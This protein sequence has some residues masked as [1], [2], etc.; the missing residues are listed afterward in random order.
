MI[1]E[2]NV[3]MDFIFFN[4]NIEELILNFNFEVE[5]R[6]SGFDIDFFVVWV[7]IAIEFRDLGGMGVY[8]SFGSFFFKLDVLN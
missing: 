8:D 5:G 7:N 4:Y 3:L 6:L 2:R 1:S